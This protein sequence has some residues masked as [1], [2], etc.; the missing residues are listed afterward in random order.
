MD[1]MELLQPDIYG[2]DWLASEF[3]GKVCFCCAVDHQRRA[4]S[5]TRE[6]IFTYA[7]VLNKRLG[8]FNGGFIADIED[9]SSLGMSEHNYQWIKE[10]CHGLEVAG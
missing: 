7:G 5:G 8:A 4:I 3:G 1:V 9:Y 2:I 6:E 10:A